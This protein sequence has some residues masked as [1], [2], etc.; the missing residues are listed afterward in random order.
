MMDACEKILGI[1][2]KMGEEENRY[3]K[4]AKML[5]SSRCKVGELEL[6]RED[7]LKPEG[8]ELKKGDTVIVYRLDKETYVR[9]A[10]VV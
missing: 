2:R 3:L 1:M 9:L 6:R 8:V 5:D 7:Y 4:R 10:K